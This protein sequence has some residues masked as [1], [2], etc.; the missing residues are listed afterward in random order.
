MDQGNPHQSNLPKSKH[1]HFSC[2]Q[3]HKNLRNILVSSRITS[4]HSQ[5][6]LKQPTGPKRCPNTRCKACNFVVESNSFR[7]THNQHTFFLKQAFTCKS[8][9]L[10]YLM[11]CLKCRKQY[12]GE[13]G[14]TLAQRITDH[15][16]LKKTNNPYWPTL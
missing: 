6:T 7:S 12:I 8:S 3:K 13:T 5:S 4:E 2:L 1:P 16:R 15:I 11:T 10:I 14:R 9:N